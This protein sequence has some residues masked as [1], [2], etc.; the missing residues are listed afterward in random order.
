MESLVSSMV[1][2]SEVQNKQASTIQ[3]FAKIIAEVHNFKTQ[4][5]PHITALMK[6]M[7]AF[8]ATI[9]SL[10]AR[11]AALETA[12]PPTPPPQITN[13][14][15]SDQLLALT[16]RIDALES[17][18]PPTPSPLPFPS[19]GPPPPFPSALPPPPSPSPSYAEVASKAANKRQNSKAKAAEKLVNTETTKLQR[20]L[21]ISCKPPPPTTIT[22]DAILASVNNAL[23]TT[24]VRFILA[25]RSLKGNLVLQTAPAN[26]ASEATKHGDTIASCLTSL[27]CTPTLMR[28]NAIWTSFLVHNIPTS[29]TAEEVA[30][31]IQLSYPSLTLCRHPRWLTTEDKR[32]E[33]THSTMVITLPQPLTLANLGLT[34]LAI[35]NQVC[36]LTLYTPKPAANET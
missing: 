26:T 11:I 30:T 19:A 31:A 23:K 7:N 9:I 24:G 25:R 35:S 15:P 29:T 5:S 16:A 32:K 17:A 27:G 20:Q 3:N 14:G 28:A 22:N 4:C 33:K 13:A 18:P 10:T 6:E 36:R 8:Q 12:P 21:V 1:S 34:S 2:L